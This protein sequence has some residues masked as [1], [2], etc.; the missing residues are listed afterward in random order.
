MRKRQLEIYG[1]RTMP[2]DEIGWRSQWLMKVAMVTLFIWLTSEAVNADEQIKQ[3]FKGTDSDLPGNVNIT[4]PD[5]YVIN[6]VDALLGRNKWGTCLTPE[7]DC[8]DKTRIFQN[9]EGLT[10]CNKTF[11]TYSPQC[12]Y[13]TVL[14]L[15]YSCVQSMVAL[16][17]SSTSTTIAT[18]VSNITT[19][20]LST[21]QEVLQEGKSR[22]VAFTVTQKP[23]VGGSTS[24]DLRETGIIIGCVLASIVTVIALVVAIVMVIRRLL[25]KDDPVAA[26]E[27]PKNPSCMDSTCIHLDSVPCFKPGSPDELDGQITRSTKK[28]SSIRTSKRKIKTRMAPVGEESVDGQVLPQSEDLVLQK[29]AQ[30]DNS[31]KQLSIEKNNS[32]HSTNAHQGEFPTI[33]TLDPNR[34]L[35][36]YQNHDSIRLKM[37]DVGNNNEEHKLNENTTRKISKPKRS[38]KDSD[39]RSPVALQK[40]ASTGNKTSDG[41]RPTVLDAVAIPNTERG[42]AC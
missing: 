37:G 12:G 23:L 31:L 9:C 29:S 5:G 4:C 20:P 26:Q 41:L 7:G 32:T 1:K 36:I 35:G 30:N 28:T 38:F 21:V 6:I 25:H 42:T 39:K 40:S 10:S 14:L 11:K 34:N 17:A 22:P 24:D 3:C 19:E 27:A 8:W 18:T 33:S 16:V 2:A 15:S 13:S